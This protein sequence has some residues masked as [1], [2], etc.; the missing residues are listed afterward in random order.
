M[1]ILVPF[2]A[3]VLCGCIG[4]HGDKPEIANADAERGRI[5]LAELECGVCHVIPGIPGAHGQVGPPLREYA[6]NVYVAGKYPNVPEVLI[7]FIRNPPLL[8]PE[9][10]M[11]AVP[12]SDAQARDI[13]AYLYS[14][15]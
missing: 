5:A 4:K 6:R 13:A 2:V 15:Q 1:R 14:S 3:G 9:T 10:A 12:M 8:A 7:E 11:P